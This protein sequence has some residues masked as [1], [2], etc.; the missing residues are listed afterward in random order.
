MPNLNDPHY[1]EPREQEGFLARRARLGRQAG[2]E[3]LGLSL[4]EVP[5]GQAAFPYHFHYTEEELVIVLEG[6]PTLRTPDGTRTLEPGEIVSFP[7]GEAGGH[8]LIN[9]GEE[10][11]R[12][13][14]FSTSGEPDLV[15]YPDSGKLGAFER[16]PDGGGLRLMFRIGD[17]VDYHDGE[18]PPRL[19]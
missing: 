1:D 8:Q 10:T 16:L 9:A 11:V 19:D 14:S 3:R 2:A 15:A 12:F 4:W 7:R 18:T 5:P 6:A 13:L 17:A